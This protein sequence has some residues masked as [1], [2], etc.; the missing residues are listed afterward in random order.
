MTVDNFVLNLYIFT[1]VLAKL[2]FERAKMRKI[3]IK[4]HKIT[5]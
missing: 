5:K 3:S 4:L 1:R 2:I